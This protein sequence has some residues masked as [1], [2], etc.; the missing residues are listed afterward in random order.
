MEAKILNGGSEESGSDDEK[1]NVEISWFDN[2][3]DRKNI[4]LDD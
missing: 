3:V 1:V 2:F 4:S